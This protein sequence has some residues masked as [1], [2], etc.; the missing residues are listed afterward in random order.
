[1]ELQSGLGIL[2]I[3]KTELLFFRERL[4]SRADETGE[5]TLIGASEL[6]DQHRIGDRLR[7]CSWI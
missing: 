5:K 6:M 3:E 1:M 4:R 7:G 2:L